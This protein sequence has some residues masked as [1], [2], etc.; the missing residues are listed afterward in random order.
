MSL[1]GVR[2]EVPSR[3]RHLRKLRVRF[4]RWDLSTAT[5]VDPRGAEMCRLL[6]VDLAANA[7]GRRRRIDPA[8]DAPEER[9]DGGDDAPLL[10]RMLEEFAATGLPPPYVPCDEIEEED[11][12]GS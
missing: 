3:F 4:A 10:K 12:D 6:P 2:F 9:A 8:A 11:G 7:D 1:R 5:A